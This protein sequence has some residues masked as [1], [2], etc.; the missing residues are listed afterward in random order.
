MYLKVRD[1]AGNACFTFYTPTLGRLISLKTTLVCLLHQ[2]CRSVWCVVKRR[3][4]YQKQTKCCYKTSKSLT[5]QTKHCTLMWYLCMNSHTDAL[6]QL[7]NAD[8]VPQTMTLSAP[9]RIG[10]H[11]AVMTFWKRYR[12]QNLMTADRPATSFDG[13]RQSFPG[14]F[15]WHLGCATSVRKNDELGNTECL[16]GDNI[17]R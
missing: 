9:T 7:L 16:R 6:K 17:A 15:T 12:R 8:W 4:L 5:F 11:S 14:Q 3:S 2:Y 1:E 10:S 13:D